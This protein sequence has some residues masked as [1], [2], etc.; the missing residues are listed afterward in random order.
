MPKKRGFD[1]MSDLSKKLYLL[2]MIASALWEPVEMQAKWR[3]DYIGIACQFGGSQGLKRKDFD[4]IKGLTIDQIAAITHEEAKTH[5]RS[6][7]VLQRR[8]VESAST[9]N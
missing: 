8:T 5:K 1:K 4:M 2:R 6:A 7:K 9:E 3:T